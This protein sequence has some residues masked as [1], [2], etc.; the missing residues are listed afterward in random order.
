MIQLT[1]QSERVIMEIGQ[2]IKE[3]RE[4]NGVSIR[5]FAK[6]VGCSYEY[7]RKLESGTKLN[8]VNLIQRISAVIGVDLLNEMNG[9]NASKETV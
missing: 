2:L 3:Y 9:D 5:Q 7:I 8:N 6:D 1:L 4:E